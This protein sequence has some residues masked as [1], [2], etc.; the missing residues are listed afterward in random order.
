M[1]LTGVVSRAGRGG[2]GGEGG[3]A[4]EAV[5]GAIPSNGVGIGVK[6]W[7]I[8]LLKLNT[9]VRGSQI[10]KKINKTTAMRNASEI[11]NCLEEAIIAPQKKRRAKNAY[12][13]RLS[14]L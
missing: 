11:E 10:R 14:I 8:I 13:R 2:E 4:G 12:L 1:A 9:F 5:E 3:E 7:Q 6:G